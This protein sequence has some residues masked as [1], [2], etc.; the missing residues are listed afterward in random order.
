MTPRVPAKRKRPPRSRHGL[1]FGGDALYQVLA[2][3]AKDPNREFT[4]KGLAEQITRTPEHTRSEIEKLLALGVVG[5]VRRERRARIYSVTGTPLSH[6]LLNL[7]RVLVK[8]L[9]RYKRR[10]A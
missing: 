3:L 2:E 10:E 1:L 4:V 5:E 9:G 6:D 8:Q 7:P